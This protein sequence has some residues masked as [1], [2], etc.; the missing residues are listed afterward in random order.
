MCVGVG[1]GSGCGCGSLLLLGWRWGCERSLDDDSVGAV[2][3]GE[4]GSTVSQRS[5]GGRVG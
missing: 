4:G 3:V 1:V 2:G 5:G